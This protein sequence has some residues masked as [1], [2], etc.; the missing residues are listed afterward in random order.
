[1]F[2]LGVFLV[3]VTII[4]LPLNVRDASLQVNRTTW[5]SL[6][7]FA[8]AFVANVP[9]L[10]TLRKKLPDTIIGVESVDEP[11]SGWTESAR[12]STSDSSNDSSSDRGTDAVRE[13]KRLLKTRKSW[14][15][16]KNFTAEIVANV[17]NIPTLLSSRK[18]AKQN[19]MSIKVTNEVSVTSTEIART[20]ASELISDFGNAEYQDHKTATKALAAFVATVDKIS[21]SY[22]LRNK[23]S[24]SLSEPKTPSEPSPTEHARST[25]NSSTKTTTSQT[26]HEQNIRSTALADLIA[27]VPTLYTLLNKPYQKPVDLEMGKEK[28]ASNWTENVRSSIS[29][30]PDKRSSQVIYA[31]KSKTQTPRPITTIEERRL[32]VML[33]PPVPPKDSPPVATDPLRT[34]PVIPRPSSS[35]SNPRPS[36]SSSNTR[37]SSSS[38][39]SS[40]TRSS[41][42]SSSSQKTPSSSSQKDILPILPL[43]TRSSRSMRLEP[44][45]E[46]RPRSIPIHLSSG[47]KPAPHARVRNGKMEFVKEEKE[48]EKG[49]QMI[50]WDEVGSMDLEIIIA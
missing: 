28:S 7:A 42:S 44:I 21:A 24:T 30:S 37:S 18:S 19:H 49:G 1:L 36:S 45:H 48:E 50:D 26:Y 16:I 47:K 31:H 46:E 27:K 20:N 22:T 8:A 43:R 10:Y 12:S 29:I 13:Q 40:N 6:E 4:R 9:A 33:P 34:S 32:A 25:S 2:S 15:S 3:I 5:V 39:S 23:S 11:A 14:S 35:P 17:S 41:S 38:S